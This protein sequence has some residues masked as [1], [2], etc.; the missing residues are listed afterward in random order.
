MGI[1]G[2]EGGA[3]SEWGRVRGAPGRALGHGEGSTD[4][5]VLQG[6]IP[7]R[8]VAADIC[9]ILG[10]GAKGGGRGALPITVCRLVWYSVHPL[11]VQG[12]AHVILDPPPQLRLQFRQALPTTLVHFGTNTTTKKDNGKKCKCKPCNRFSHWALSASLL[13]LFATSFPVSP[14]NHIVMMMRM[15]CIAGTSLRQASPICAS[16]V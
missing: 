5:N 12:Q 2:S 13:H 10:V 16:E 14:L 8:G 15:M 11:G 3:G 9:A 7:L 6:G 4:L 1:L